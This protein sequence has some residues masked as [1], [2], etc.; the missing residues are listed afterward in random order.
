MEKLLEFYEKQINIL[1]NALEQIAASNQ[2]EQNQKIVKQAL[3]EIKK[4][5]PDI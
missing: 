1:K 2:N 4:M 5:K 3:T